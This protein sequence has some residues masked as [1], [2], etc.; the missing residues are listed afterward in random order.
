M[1]SGH[2]NRTYRPNTWLDRP[3]LEREDFPCQPGAT[4]TWHFSYV[5]SLTDDV[6]SLGQ[7][8]L[9]PKTPTL[10]FLTQL[11]HQPRLFADIDSLGPVTDAFSPL[12]T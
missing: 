12:G 3:S 8:G 7:S 11:R 5:T 6:R 9:D 1:A 10:P 4:H 2:V